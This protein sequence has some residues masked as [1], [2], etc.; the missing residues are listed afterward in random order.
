MITQRCERGVTVP[1]IGAT[2]SGPV[3]DYPDKCAETTPGVRVAYLTGPGGQGVQ[4][5]AGWV[6]PR[7]LQFQV[8]PWSLYRQPVAVV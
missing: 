4:N 6:R 2:W 8:V 3:P 5:G 7:S 1:A